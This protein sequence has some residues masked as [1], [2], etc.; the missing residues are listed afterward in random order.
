MLV[1]G[2]RIL[3]DK[4]AYRFGPVERG[5][6]VV[7]VNPNERQR[8]LVKRI[9]ALPGDVVEIKKSHLLVNGI[10]LPRVKVDDLGENGAKQLCGD[11][12][13]ETNGTATYHIY[14]VTEDIKSSQIPRDFPKTTVPAGHCFVLGDNRRKS[15]DSRELGPIPLGDIIGQAV[16][17]YFPRCERLQ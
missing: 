12:F 6:I 7:V 14:M 4:R 1:D 8:R 9:V 5:D 10:E 15:Q 2:D 11:V 16:C 13:Q 3:V 17:V